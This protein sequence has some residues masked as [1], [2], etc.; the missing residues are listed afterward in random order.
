MAPPVLHLDWQEVCLLCSQ[1]EV[2]SGCKVSKKWYYGDVQA[3]EGPKGPPGG[4]SCLVRQGS[5]HRGQALHQVA[6]PTCCWYSCW[7]RPDVNSRK[8]CASCSTSQCVSLWSSARSSARRSDSSTAWQSC[9]SSSPLSGCR[10]QTP[11]A[12]K[13]R[14]GC[15]SLPKPCRVVL[16]SR[17][18]CCPLQVRRQS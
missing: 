18:L 11:S 4:P 10:S 15:R 1:V 17:L 12:S 14:F 16:T 3:K 13:N 5:H 2:S 6:L 7:W 9:R 8:H